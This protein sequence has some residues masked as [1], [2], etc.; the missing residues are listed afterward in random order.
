MSTDAFLA[1]DARP[2]AGWQEEDSVRFIDMGEVMI[3][4]RDEM[5]QAMLDLIPAASE[6]A[7]T[8][9]EIGCGSGWLSETLLTRYPNARVIAIDGSPTML[10]RAA[11]WLTPF[12]SR[13]Q[14]LLGRLEE[15]DW[16]DRLE[17]PV[18]C[19]LSS[20]TLHHLDGPGKANLFADLYQRL[21]PGGALCYADIVEPA[22]GWARQHM[23]R[24]WTEAVCRRSLAF[25]GKTETFDFFVKEQWNIYD[26]PDPE[27]D[28]PSPLT[29]LIQWLSAAGFGQ[30]DVPWAMAGHVVIVAYRPEMRAVPDAE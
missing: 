22:S 17:Q 23:A 21:E 3:P 18:R 11:E 12:G 14:L 2:A 26:Y 24:A 30:I 13:A 7:F 20:L 28:K 19:F 10:G 6:D 29:S 27:V 4:T 9:V 1:P 25:T 15:R 16:L 5:G 8:A